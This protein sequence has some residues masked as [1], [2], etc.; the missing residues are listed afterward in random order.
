MS[1][2]E[3]PESVP[4]LTAKDIHRGGYD[5]PGGSHCLLGHARKCG[6]WG[7]GEQDG[8]FIDAMKEHVTGA[9][10]KIHEFNDDPANSR[11]KIAS[12]WNKAMRSLGYTEIHEVDA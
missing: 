2:T 3:W 9:Y 10:I 12:A 1:S 11:R 4:V 8:A 5:G 6:L 7:I